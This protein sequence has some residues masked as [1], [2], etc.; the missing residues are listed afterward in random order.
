[1]Q[2]LLEVLLNKCRRSLGH[3]CEGIG[4]NER[5]FRAR[6]H[7]ISDIGNEKALFHYGRILEQSFR[8]YVRC[9]KYDDVE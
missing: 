6:C 5:N 8:G 3:L 9:K 1:M 2:K 4:V 7:T